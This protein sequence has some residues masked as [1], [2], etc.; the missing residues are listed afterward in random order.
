MSQNFAGGCACGAI[1]FECNVDPVVALNCHCRDCQRASGGAYSPIV[2]FPKVSVQLAGEPRY[3]KVVG[4]NGK[5]IERG[6]CQSCGSQ[7]TMKWERLAD[8]FG[9]QAGCLDDPS[10]YKPAMDVFTA[11]AQPWEHMD[12]NVQKHVGAPPI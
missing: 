2:A 9:L 1:R 4:K 12:P 5:A 6:F 10:L 3:H 11:S 7:V 8:F